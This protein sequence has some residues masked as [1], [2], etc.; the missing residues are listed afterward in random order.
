[1]S[2]LTRQQAIEWCVEKGADFM[3]PVYPPPSGWAWAESGNNQSNLVL[4]QIFT[5]D[6]ADIH[7]HDLLPA[8]INKMNRHLEQYM[9]TS[10]SSN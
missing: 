7:I 4:T 10:P 1:M 2:D 5:G 3:T 8:F 9:Q 6:G